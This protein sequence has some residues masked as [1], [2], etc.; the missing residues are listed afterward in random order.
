MTGRARAPRSAALLA[1]VCA[2]ATV[3][4]SGCGAEEDPDKG[5]NGV[6]KLSPAKIEMKA[7]KAAEKAEAVRVSGN[8]VSKGQTYRIKM[9]LKR[10][11]GVG[12]VSAQGGATFELLRV[13]S[14][15]YLKAG[16]DFWAKQ[17]KGGSEPTKSD[18]AAAGKLE[19][20]YVKVPRN[21]PAYK[22]LSGFTDMGVLLDGLLA[23]DGKR[24]A[25]DRGQVDG[26]KTVRVSAGAGR[27][28]TIDVSLKGSPYPLRLQRGGDAGTVQLSGWNRGF[29]LSA[30]SK[31]ETVDYGKQISP[32]KH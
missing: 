30:P 25:G 2:G 10:D 13:R 9:R 23:M 31:N 22:Q 7:R 6:G 8:V 14:D 17:E 5:T 11:G 16:T 1:V 19:G 3:A 12:E 24:E 27:G 15:L 26:V 29:E 20:K 32:S 28:G 18:V 21:D 4:L